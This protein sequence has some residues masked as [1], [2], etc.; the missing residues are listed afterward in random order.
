[1]YLYAQPDALMVDN[2]KYVI[3][4]ANFGRYRF[5]TLRKNPTSWAF[6]G[7]WVS[8]KCL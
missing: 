2:A 4:N 8:I 5:S 1:M 3:F 6:R 7:H